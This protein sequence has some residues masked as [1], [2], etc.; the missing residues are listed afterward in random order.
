MTQKKFIFIVLFID[1][2]SVIN[3]RPYKS[4][5]LFYV[6]RILKIDYVNHFYS[7]DNKKEANI[8]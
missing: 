4:D 3:G 8:L 7:L 2:I 5:I 1:H 6:S